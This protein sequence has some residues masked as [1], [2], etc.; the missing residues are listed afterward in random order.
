MPTPPSGDQVT[1]AAL[2]DLFEYQVRRTPDA[3]AVVCGD[4]TLSYTELNARANGLAHR[5]VGRGVAVGDIVAVA[6]SRTPEFVVAV[7]AVLKAGAGY[8]SVDL[9]YPDERITHMLEDSAP[10]L[11]ITDTVGASG[12]PAAATPRLVV[13][14]PAVRARVEAC[15]ATDL[16]DE[17]RNGTLDVLD[18]AYVVYTSGSTG[19]PKPV[20][21]VHRG[22]AHLVH[23]HRR[24]LRV[25]VGCRVLQ[26]A[27]P[28]FD[29]FV[30]ELCTAL[31]TGAALV[32]P[33]TAA[34]LDGDRLVRLLA[35]ENVTHAILPPALVAALPG[36]PLPHGLCLVVAGEA[37]PSEVV[38]RYATR[39]PLFN[40]YG[41]S[42]STVCATISEPLS[43]AAPGTPPIGRSISGTE[44]H[45]LDAWLRP[46]PRGTAGEVYISGAGLARGYGRRPAL[47]AERFV[48]C[49]FGPAGARM[50]RTGDVAR[51]NAEGE[52]EFVGRVDDQVKIR[53]FRVEPGEVETVLARH[54]GVER[55]VVVAREDRPGDKRLVAYVVPRHGQQVADWSDLYDEHYGANGSL[56]PGTDFRG[57]NSS[58][59]GRPLPAR[60]MSAWRDATVERIRD[61][62]PRRVLEIGV[63][64]GLL[65]APLAPSCEEYW[66]TDLSAVAVERLG[67][68]VAAD[69]GLAGRVLLRAQGAD[70]D[71]GIPEEY[72]DTV[73]INSVVQY[74]PDLAYLE[75]VLDLA[76]R[77][78]VPGGHLFLGDVRNL[79]LLG[80][81]HAGVL[82]ARG[83]EAGRER[84]LPDLLRGAMDGERE[85]LV[86]PAFFTAYRRR[87]PVDLV[88]SRVKDGA[89]RNE[90]TGYR[91]DVVL[92]R[93]ATGSSSGEATDSARDSGPDGTQVLTW[94]REVRSLEELARRLQSGSVSR[95]HVVGVPNA[96]VAGD[97][98]AQQAILDGRPLDGARDS[99]ARATADGRTVDPRAL[100]DL[101]RESDYDAAVSWS[102]SAADGCLD[103]RFTRRRGGPLATPPLVETEPAEATDTAVTACANVPARAAGA[104]TLALSLRR[105]AAHALPAFMVPNAVV[106]LDKLPLSPHGKVDRRALPAPDAGPADA[107]VPGRGPHTPWEEILC[108]LFAQVLGLDGVGPDDGFF[109]LGGHSLLAMKLIGRVRTVL[110]AELDLGTLF[111]HSTPA[112]LATRLD[113]SRRGRAP[114]VRVERRPERIPLS[115]A[116][117]RLW[118]TDQLR[119]PNR[120][121]NVPY[122]ARLTGALDLVALRAAFRDLVARHETLR[123]VLPSVDGRP[124]QQI[125][126]VDAAAPTVPVR[127]VGEADL[128]AAVE[129]A[130]GC[131]FDLSRDTPL[132]VTVLRLRP[133]E[134]VLVLVMH[135]IATDGWSV[136]LLT[137]DLSAAYAARRAGSPP[138]WRELPVQYADY[139]LRRGEPLDEEAAD[140]IEEW[141]SVLAG[142]PEE[143]ALPWDRPR[144]AVAGLRGET[145]E[146]RIGAQLHEA[147]GRLG[148]DHQATLFMVLHAGLAALLGRLGAGTDIPIGTAVAGRDDES[149]DEL[150]GFFVNSL[151]L[152]VDTSG[153]PGFAQL[154][155]RVR[156]TDLAAFSRQDAPFDR[157]VELINPARSASRHPLFQVMLALDSNPPAA[158][159][160]EGLDVTPQQV[161]PG[162]CKF[163]LALE[164]REERDLQ[165]SPAGLTARWQYAAE[166]F[167]RPTVQALTER[168]LQ[169]LRSVVEA[170][171]RPLG[172]CDVL[173]PGERD[174]L[175]GDWSGA[176]RRIPA[177]TIPRLFEA[178]ARRTPQAAAVVF[179]DEVLSYAELNARA[180]T[181][182]HQLAHR[183]VAPEAR[184]GVFLPRSADLVVALLGVLKAGG[185]FVPL[186]PEYPARRLTDMLADAQPVC[187]V[188]GRTSRGRLAS[189]ASPG[190]Q[191]GL[192]A[193]H[194]ASAAVRDPL[195]IDEPPLP[196][197]AED[198]RDDAPYA[199]AS[200]VL[201]PAHAAY[202]I[203]TSGS[204]GRPKGVTVTH[205]AVVELYA[206]NE[207]LFRSS[208]G[209]QLRVALTSSLCF[210]AS[211]DQL[212]CLFGG[213]ALHVLDEWTMTDPALLAKEIV[214]RGI[215][216]VNTTPSLMEILLQEGLL[217]DA[218][219]RPRRIVVGGEAPGPRLWERLR[220]V[221]GVTAY[222][223]YG[224]TECSVDAVR[225]EVS[226]AAS[227]VLGR[228]LLNTRAFVLDTRLAL[229]PP[230]VV[231]E[232]HLAGS[233]LARGY[234]GAPAMTAQ[235]F[236]ACPF[237]PPG[238]RMYRT[239]DLVRWTR[240]GRLEFVGRAD[241]QVKIRGYRIELAEVE[242]A[243]ASD[244]SVARAMASVQPDRLG[245]PRLVAHVVPA[246]G[247]RDGEVDTPSVDTARLRHFVAGV[248]PGYMVPA[249]VV[250][251]RAL[252]TTPSGKLER[253]S[254]AVPD[255]G[256]VPSG[257]APRT[258]W[259]EVLCGL[260]GQVL[261]LDRVAVDLSFFDQ[262]GHSLLAAR[263]TALVRSSLGVPMEVRDLFEAPTVEALAAR[264]ESAGAA[265]AEHLGVREHLTRI[266]G[267]ERRLASYAQRRL[268]LLDQFEGPNALYNVPLV[269]RLSGPLD[270]DA[271]AAAFGDVVRRHKALRVILSEEEGELLQAPL[272]ME[273]LRGRFTVEDVPEGELGACIAQSVAHEF[274]LEREAPY[275]VQLLRLGARDHVCVAVMHHIA[276]DGHSADPLLRDLSAAY[277]ARRAGHAPRWKEPA[278]EYADF[279]IWQRRVLGDLEDPESLIARQLAYWRR[280]LDG[281]PAQLSLPYD[282]VRPSLPT[283]RAAEAR[284]TVDTDQGKRLREVAQ[285]SGATL[286][287][288]LHAAVAVMLSWSGAGDDVV[289]GTVA[290]GRS[291]PKLDDVVG[292]FVNNLVLR[293][294]LSDEPSL[295]DFLY[296]VR[297]V[298]LGAFAHQ[299][300][301][302]DVLVDA[303]RPE[304]VEGRNPLFQVA[305]T[306]EREEDA[307]AL[308]LPG[309]RV[310]ALPQKQAVAK[311]DLTIITTLKEDG[312]LAGSIAYAVDLFDHSTVESM[313]R[314]LEAV[315]R[316]FSTD[317][318]RSVPRPETNP[319]SQS[320]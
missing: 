44:V 285:S 140:R 38:R 76:L 252:P 261:G 271:L 215:D 51:W 79:R 72:F 159:R 137:R 265:S 25:G 45:V 226:E 204:T 200:P 249:V 71:E 305:L 87:A 70:D 290:A 266:R 61:L 195:V 239:G 57:W 39:G 73:V 304:R 253:Q 118:F 14:D 242:A 108:G 35:D 289:L 180:D 101:G 107:A 99:A 96:R 185:V 130:V 174:R 251:V 47:T 240:Q 311:F 133:D 196:C 120:A 15:P 85:L 56:P 279:A 135:H 194:P 131:P 43:D 162:E 191:G 209:R 16:R 231:G 214:R 302:F 41:P 202:V 171:E 236:V 243:L 114:H 258:A 274:D 287:M 40:A 164:L 228:P 314:R 26:F 288:V 318:L 168:F 18:L 145:L 241:E 211:W 303:L 173:L 192:P 36:P 247:G 98:A 138:A 88:C 148:R 102:R 175:L 100:Y 28:S 68:Q 134:H 280:R 62:G 75:R 316:M 30:S 156:N 20:H 32:L 312:G 69:P 105:H 264:L 89:H 42:E 262:G 298:V 6:M 177:A 237:G 268:W 106:V 21:T 182:A 235:R 119:G 109:D 161:E 1:C 153:D 282:R 53:G 125:L 24:T 263:L 136:G 315:L 29:A 317:P 232:L 123:T 12:L 221:P 227:P 208:G 64:N 320:V 66:G 313:C 319:T 283:R 278:V 60:E 165:G 198:C 146:F 307:V 299:D 310:T 190:A 93:A 97:L 49:P 155:E 94:G 158:L 201:D 210:D 139:A 95:A 167:D 244:P 178:Q 112:L 3:D 170:P 197:P 48:A 229:V 82:L 186:D 224:P 104:G 220:S 272:P 86:D 157:L 27:S 248:L 77:C 294:D 65:L 90:L 126:P 22:L 306:F 255:E 9:T 55:A 59:D 234:I 115:F 103:V 169:V 223:A 110:G 10:S 281:L 269:F 293:T 31:L 54:G 13:D 181:L 276:F 122:V 245:N 205:Q 78:L 273:S 141:R 83:V 63:G 284:F 225:A 203:Y 254:L 4:E 219:R 260:F 267:G 199:C 11:V 84:E 116:Q 259:Q 213:H 297:D 179:G 296:R 127:A 37:C 8:L 188:T 92:R 111:D 121:Y 295:A 160:L 129:G 151:V 33:D 222:N 257:R 46:V 113:A 34:P 166:L 206:A 142:L 154:L 256:A 277:A 230:G 7:L 189:V 184:V 172:A 58:Y 233:G 17:D 218:H 152:R 250:P 301:P 270:R 2:P 246:D 19:R 143:L 124:Y 193:S 117:Q 238:S 309:V 23:Q 144:S 52:L 80:A 67:A 176:H 81:F 183:G 91:Y 128:A 147:L 291:D 308:D 187:V 275:R 212:M 132:R 150:V 149:L 216:F 292:F 217:D 286:F 50:Y 300:V 74:F 5:L 207:E 163:D